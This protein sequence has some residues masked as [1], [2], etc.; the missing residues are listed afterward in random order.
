[1]N[2]PNTLKKPKA[3][4]AT[5]CGVIEEAA[6]RT[7]EKREARIGPQPWIVRKLMVG[8]TLAVMAYSAYVFVARLCVDMIRRK[9]DA[10][11]SRTT[12]IGLV[13]AFS[14]L[15]LWM[16]WAYM[17][18]LSDSYTSY[19]RDHTSPGAQ[20]MYPDP[21]PFVPYDLAVE[22]T[23]M[24]QSRPSHSLTPSSDMD[25]GSIAGPSYENLTSSGPRPTPDF[26]P[27]Q[28]PANTNG[29]N[30]GHA[31]FDR[32]S[33]PAP[34]AAAIQEKSLGDG[35]SRRPS[36]KPVLRPEQRY[37][38]YDEIV[39]PYRT[40]HCR[41]CGTC[42]LKYDHHCPWIGQCVG[43]RNQK[44]FLNFTTAASAY[45]IYV[46]AALIVFTVRAATSPRGDLDPQRIIII[47][48]AAVF[49]MFTTLMQ[50]SHIGMICRGQTT[51]ESMHARNMKE[52]EDRAL[53]DVFGTCAFVCVVLAFVLVLTGTV[54]A[55]EIFVL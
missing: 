6:H 34:G 30:H 9:E 4:G 27:F 1:M 47:A 19:A 15:F 49:A 33:E 42:V 53:A 31:N 32:L 21:A 20:P 7:R 45:T 46:C 22:G 40:H 52:R 13:S 38:P 48:L 24:S 35:I 29:N 39:K 14:V 11:G 25:L 44:F 50:V 10:G 5:C 43:A 37:C 8:F 54:D 41:T 12:G 3:K 17:K 55:D 18:V 26:P 23:R 28:M 16:L 51:I 36:L 2:S